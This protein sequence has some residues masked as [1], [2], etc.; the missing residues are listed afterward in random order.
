[1]ENDD[2]GKRAGA[3]RLHELERD[4]DRAVRRV[5]R[6]A[7]ADIATRRDGLFHR[8]GCGD[9][10][11][12]AAAGEKDQRAGGGTAAQRDHR[13]LHGVIAILGD[14]ATNSR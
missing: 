13:S 4:L 7:A 11:G 2:G 5:D 8:A 1:M 6:E 9:A 12:S 14:K 3:V 10:A